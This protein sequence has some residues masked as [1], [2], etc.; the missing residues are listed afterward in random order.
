MTEIG[1]DSE[2]RAEQE[3]WLHDLLGPEEARRVGK[4][5][6]MTA[7]SKQYPLPEAPKRWLV[8]GGR[9]SGKTRLGAEWVRALI[10]GLPPFTRP[11][12]SYG[13][14]ALVAETL[15]DAR[16]VM[17]DGASGILATARGGEKPRFE[18]SRRRVLFDNG[19]TAQIFSSEDPDALRGP[20]FDA[21]WC[22]E[23]GAPAVDGGATRPNLFVDGKSSES[24]TPDGSNGGRDD[25]IQRRFL[26]AH[27]SHWKNR[28]ASPVD[29][30]RLYLWAWDTRP[31]PAFP[32]LDDIWS[33]GNAWSRG[34]WLN[35]RLEQVELGDCLAALL[36]RAGLCSFDVSGVDAMVEGV[37]LEAGSA[38]R[39]S[40]SPILDL[41]GI[42]AFEQNGL[43]TFRSRNRRGSV[44][45][46]GDPVE[47]A[48]D[49]PAIETHAS[50]METVGEV[51]AAAR[52]PLIEYQSVV[53]RRFESGAEQKQ[54]RQI[55]F[56]GA[57]H[58]GALEA[59]AADQLRRA[60]EERITL[61]LSLPPS[62][63]VPQPGCRF[64]LGER[65][66]VVW[67]IE[68]VESG[69]EVRLRASRDVAFTP[70]AD[71]S[72]RPDGLTAQSVA[73]QGGAPAVSFL[74]LPLIDGE[75]PA[76]RFRVAAWSRFWM[77]FSVT[78]AP[79]GSFQ[80]RVIIDDPATMGETVD[81]L[82][83]ARPGRVMRTT[84][85]VQLFA[86]SLSSVERMDLLAG[87]NAAAIEG[88][89][90]WEIVQFESAEEIA[91]DIWV[92]KGLL[93]GQLGTEDV[94]ATRLP[95]GSNFVLLDSAVGVAGLRHAEI[96]MEMRW[97]VDPAGRET[98]AEDRIETMKAGGVR[99]SLP[100]A[101]VHP[102]AIMVDDAIRFDW[103][104]R[105]RV[106]ADRWEGP[107]IPLG[108]EDETYDVSILDET[109]NTL[110]SAI[111]TAPLWSVPRQ[112]FSEPAEE[113]RLKVC[114]V[115]RTM[116]A[117]I[118]M[119]ARFAPQTLSPICKRRLLI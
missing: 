55:A 27:L 105:G 94:A 65:P 79:A 97:R 28:Q 23:L 119:V 83:P 74:D 89:S 22:D 70:S 33:D 43:L 115:S 21:A 54:A 58:R 117:G 68:E 103:I 19:A 53:A 20:Q 93:R 98:S 99:A 116:G 40:L 41:H 59:R 108:E 118:P 90:G 4:E 37:V 78:A 87:A 63:S 88:S 11:G 6:F 39:K 10:L 76:S 77:P 113:H 102:C 114:Q 61:A 18:A 50:P 82:P 85:R 48:E 71:N 2:W 75:E 51:L 49:G 15:G 67:K 17:V 73:A 64:R 110:T 47:R 9:G 3:S 34:H 7:R 14:I 45:L 1:L 13:R 81:D 32:L 5:W 92:L 44:G 112:V 84:L 36:R 100:L 57:M 69:L 109:G 66:E 80:E 91:S 86:G 12:L 46:V 62:L 29:P 8:V 56:P 30:E 101:P 106:E 111:V 42:E 38:L 24:A 16:E 35:G 107:D 31:Y 26:R 25:L 96:G 60:Q 95:L 72:I 52:E 104:R